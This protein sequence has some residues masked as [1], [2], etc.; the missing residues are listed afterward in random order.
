M[1]EICNGGTFKSAGDNFIQRQ[2]GPTATWAALALIP[3]ASEI[4]TL[5]LAGVQGQ[6]ALT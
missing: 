2:Y 5:P 6:F 3:D 4:S 1:P